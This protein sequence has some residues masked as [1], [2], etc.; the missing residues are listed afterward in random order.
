MN[1]SERAQTLAHRR[2]SLRLR[3]AAQRAELTY[4]VGT[5]EQRL[6]RIDNTLNSVRRVAAKPLMVGIG[7]AVLALVGPRRL[8]RWGTR[9]A[10][11]AT[12]VSR[13]VKALR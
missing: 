11:A 10:L 12:T 6:S 13:L 2:E 3:A 8:L 4:D 5:I 1:L 7:V 9:S